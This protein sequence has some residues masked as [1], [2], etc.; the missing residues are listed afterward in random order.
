MRQMFR[1]SLERLCATPECG[2]A[3]V[4]QSGADMSLKIIGAGFPRTGTRSLKAALEQLGYGPCHHMFDVVFSS[5]QAKAWHAISEGAKPEWDKVLSGYQACVDFPSSLY[6]KALFEAYPDAKVILT[7]RPPNDWYDS[8][9]KT[10]Y[11]VETSVPR[12]LQLTFSRIGRL[13]QMADTLIWNGLFEGKFEER[14]QAIVEFERHIDDV[15]AAIPRDQ[16]LVMEVKDG[17][18]PLCV[19]LGVEEPTT[20]FPRVNDKADF[21][22]MTKNLRR[23]SWV[24][25]IA[26]GVGLLAVS[27]IVALSLWPSL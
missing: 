3:R 17:W 21:R 22:R 7:V 4:D 5:R 23:L 6:Y 15:K 26:A 1:P 14:T 8:M 24:P 19:F 27:G 12:W 2:R 11:R 25:W 13:T 10:L 16:L 9:I 20:P 18:A